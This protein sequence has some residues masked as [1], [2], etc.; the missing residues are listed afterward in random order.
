MHEANCDTRQ[1]DVVMFQVDQ[2]S[3]DNTGQ[4]TEPR[5]LKC[6]TE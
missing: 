6:G 3:S 2:W 4:N 5:Q 1:V